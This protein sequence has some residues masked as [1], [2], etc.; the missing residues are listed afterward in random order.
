[1]STAKRKPPTL[2]Q[3][4]DEVNKKALIWAGSVIGAI[5]V[6]VTVLLIVT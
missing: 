6:V 1:M 4:R 3:K 2:Q 5:V